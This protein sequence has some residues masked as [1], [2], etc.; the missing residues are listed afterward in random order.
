MT[1]SGCK[2]KIS[3]IALILL[4][5]ASA[6][7]AS[8][9][10]NAQAAT[11]E[12]EVIKAAVYEHVAE[13]VPV[14]E[15]CSLNLQYLKLPNEGYLTLPQAENISL[16]LK[17][18]LDQLVTSRTIVRVKLTGDNGRTRH[19][20]VP[21]LI[22]VERPVWQAK[23]RVQPGQALT[24]AV[25][26][27]VRE[28]V[29]TQLPHQMPVDAKLEDYEARVVIQPGRLI[30]DR[31]IQ[32]IPMVKAHQEVRI[33]IQLSRKMSVTVL[34]EAL[35]SGQEGQSIRVRQTR[36]RR[37]DYHATVIAPGLVRVAM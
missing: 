17:S 4:L 21:V 32:R 14:C 19:I 10:S 18:N 8:H 33:Q 30:D 3:R 24:P 28:V 31:C 35:E 29:T 25:V 9:V 7:V 5:L 11:V 26:K 16:E 12:A 36:P 23:D 13:Y 37:K 1:Y 27:T 6:L 20:G 22:G 15:G 34:G 2:K